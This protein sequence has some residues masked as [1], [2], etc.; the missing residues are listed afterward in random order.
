MA[1][2]VER[3]PLPA[4][5]LTFLD[6]AN[7]RPQ[8]HHVAQVLAS[9]LP[10]P[11][12]H[13]T[14]AEPPEQSRQRLEALHWAPARYSP[15][16]STPSI[17]GAVTQAKLQVCSESEGNLEFSVIELPSSPT[18]D[19]LWPEPSSCNSLSNPRSGM[20]A[21]S[22]VCCGRDGGKSWFT[23][24]AVLLSVVIFLLFVGTLVLVLRLG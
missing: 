22:K 2:S 12:E 15:Y 23:C 18:D 3:P 20:E 10:S 1:I 16:W 8:T 14:A 6:S 11:V 5:D 4:L 13:R 7:F 21:V 9:M 17:E 24:R 19:D